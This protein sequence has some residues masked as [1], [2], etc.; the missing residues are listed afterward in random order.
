MNFFKTIFFERDGKMAA[1][2]EVRDCEEKEDVEEE[3]EGKYP[4]L[5]L[6]YVTFEN[7]DDLVFLYKVQVVIGAYKYEHY[8]SF[9]ASEWCIPS[10]CSI[11]GKSLNKMLARY[12]ECRES[13]VSKMHIA[14]SGLMPAEWLV[15]FI[16]THCK[17]LKKFYPRLYETLLFLCKEREL[18]LIRMGKRP[19]KGRERL[20][21][22]HFREVFE[23]ST[24]GSFFTKPSWPF[25][26][27]EIEQRYCLS[28]LR[29]ESPLTTRE[30]KE[31]L[32]R[33]EEKEEEEEEEELEYISGNDELD[34]FI[35]QDQQK[36]PQN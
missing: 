23:G 19:D 31:K 13:D 15:E 18:M 29:T 9:I 10:L 7:Y 8:T 36:S 5:P 34:Y 27:D 24:R 33:E 22:L 20:I 2:L 12:T 3:V 6:P 21:Q 26:E 1:E 30:E 28:D 25:L 35:D 4:Y 14:L 16:R 11:L 17:H 32:R